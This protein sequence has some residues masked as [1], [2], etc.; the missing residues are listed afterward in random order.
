MIEKLRNTV[1]KFNQEISKEF[2]LQGA[3]L[4][5][6]IKFDEIYKKYPEIKDKENINI[7]KQAI[8]KNEDNPE[9][10]R[11]LTL[12]LEN[13][14]NEVISSELSSLSEELLLKEASGKLEL[15]GKDVY[16]RSSMIEMINQDDRNMREMIRKK[17]NEFIR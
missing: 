11:K 2:Y 17:R 1:E 3:G 8:S 15:N 10:S 16:F 4:K 14:Y 9:E 13:I 12:F 7:L 6:D 5:D